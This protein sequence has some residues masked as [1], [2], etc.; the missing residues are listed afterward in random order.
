VLVVRHLADRQ[1]LAFTSVL[2]LKHTR[3]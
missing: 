3:R 2:V 1:G